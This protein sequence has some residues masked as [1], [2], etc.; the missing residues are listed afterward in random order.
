[1]YYLLEV[2]ENGRNTLKENPHAFNKIFKKFGTKE[3]A[4]NYLVERYGR[5]PRGKKKVYMDGENGKPIEVGFLHSFWNKDWSHDSKHWFQTDW[6][7]LEKVT[8][9]NFSRIK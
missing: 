6:I 3:D 1:M 9:T 8:P 4:R 5:M 7:T 2:T